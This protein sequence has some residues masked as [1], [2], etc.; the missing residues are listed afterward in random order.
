MMTED[1]VRMLADQVAARSLG[2]WGFATSDVEARP[3]HDGDAAF[4]VTL[5]FKPGSA[6]ADAH[7]Y[8]DALSDLRHGLQ[9]R[10]EIRFPYLNLDYPDD[11]PPFEDDIESATS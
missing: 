2:P 11:P 4:F 8:S 5:H 10:G 9:Q 1:E 6:V 3:D 7:A